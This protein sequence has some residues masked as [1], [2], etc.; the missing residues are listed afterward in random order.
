MCIFRSNV[1][2]LSAVHGRLSEVFIVDFER[3]FIDIIRLSFWKL[4]IRSAQKVSLI[5]LN[6]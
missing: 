1:V 2:L 5:T 4:Y 6:T 3:E